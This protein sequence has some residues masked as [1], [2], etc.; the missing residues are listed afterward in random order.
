MGS[1]MCIRDRSV[2]AGAEPLE[3]PSR[4]KAAPKAQH[5]QQRFELGEH[6]VGSAGFSL[7]AG[8]ADCWSLLA[9]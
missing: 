3:Q 7:V 8:E 4:G 1:E 2:A 9:F 5:Q 6:G